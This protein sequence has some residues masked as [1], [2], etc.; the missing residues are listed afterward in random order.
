MAFLDEP[1]DVSDLPQPERSYEPVPPG[2]YD[3]IITSADVTDTKAGTGKYIKIRYDITS[4]SHQGRVVF[5]NL[6]I[7]NPNAKA[8]SIGRAQLN[9][10]MQA[11]NITRLA[12]TD[13]LVGMPVFIK[14]A[15]KEDPNYGASNEVKGFKG[16]VGGVAAA[17]QQI[18]LSA[19]PAAAITAKAAP[20]WAKK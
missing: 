7:R 11:V 17:P 3:A 2:W 18:P 13:Q 15:V 16:R 10:L 20:P 19:S 9:E 4:P 6:N 1:I 5:G 14:L 8:E 12:N